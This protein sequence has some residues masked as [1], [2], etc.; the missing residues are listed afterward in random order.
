MVSYDEMLSLEYTLNQNP[1]ELLNIPIAFDIPQ[2]T[3]LHNYQKLMKTTHPDQY[4]TKPEKEHA[5][6]KSIAI[7]QAFEKLKNPIQRAEILL[8][9]LHINAMDAQT[10]PD[11]L[12]E[13]MRLQE[14]ND[15]DTA[16]KAFDDAQAT[17]AKAFLEKD[18]PAL[19]KN[20]L[21][22]KYLSRSMT[23]RN[24]S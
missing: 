3:L 16:K 19:K 7:N 11:F 21:T 9:L 12:E 24:N 15:T 22:M 4:L 13:M 23:K 2:N 10:Q 18:I 20:Y 17:F 6:T 1:F 14:M 5:I 8:E